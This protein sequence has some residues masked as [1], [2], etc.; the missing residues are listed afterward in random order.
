M[1]PDQNC[2]CCLEGST[3]E[4]TKYNGVNNAQH[5]SHKGRGGGGKRHPHK[6]PLYTGPLV[7]IMNNSKLFVNAGDNTSLMIEVCSNPRA[8]RIFWIAPN[9]R[10]LKISG[11]EKDIKVENLI[12]TK[13]IESKVRVTCVQAQLY[14]SN[15]GW[16][17]E[18]EYT[19]IA[20]NRYGFDGDSIVVKVAGGVG[21]RKL[22]SR[23][24][25]RKSSRKRNSEQMSQINASSMDV[26]TSSF[27]ST[28]VVSMAIYYFSIVRFNE[29][30][31][32][33]L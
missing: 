16:Q 24:K 19:L 14:I 26:K 25:E 6:H 12:A 28:F 3:V 4:R 1:F 30:F 21:R 22:R 10:S 23:E 27:V 15:F 9:F 11:R 33:F 5:S 32:F 17:D 13:V 20:K 18:G 31:F 8:H 29:L 7:R 2:S